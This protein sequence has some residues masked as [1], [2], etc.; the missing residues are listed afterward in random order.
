MDDEKGREFSMGSHTLRNLVHILERPINCADHDGGWAQGKTLSCI[1]VGVAR[2]HLV[3]TLLLWQ[4]HVL[5]HR[6]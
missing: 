6:S 3:C 5:L 1:H 2:S 4:V